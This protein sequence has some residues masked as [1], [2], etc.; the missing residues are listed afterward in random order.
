MNFC[1]ELRLLESSLR[2]AVSGSDHR[3][4]LSASV[5][6]TSQGVHDEGDG[7]RV[8][9]GDAPAGRRVATQRQ[10]QNCSAHSRAPGRSIIITRKYL[11]VHE[12][13]SIIQQ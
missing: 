8:P 2:T 1:Q 3:S 12:R 11:A 9:D 6:A 13:A 7:I 4:A 10:Q 5:F